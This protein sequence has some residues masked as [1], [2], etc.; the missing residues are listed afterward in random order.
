[1]PALQFG[2]A[3]PSGN[4]LAAQPPSG[5][6]LPLVQWQHGCQ[7]LSDG[8]IKAILPQA[9]GI[10]RLPVRSPSSTSTRCPR[11]TRARPTMCPRRRCKFS[12]G[13]PDKY[14]SDGAE[15]LANAHKD[16]TKYPKGFQERERVIIH[17]RFV[18]ER[19][20]AEI[21]RRLDCSQ[22]HVPRLLSGTLARLRD[23]IAVNDRIY[24]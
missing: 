10:K 22:M 11:P 5:H 2:F 23:G 8:E 16:A 21:G 18:E 7:V 20:Q 13:L 19:T 9:D 15:D 17:M 3:K 4:R 14:D 6:S 1:M 24:C 12:F